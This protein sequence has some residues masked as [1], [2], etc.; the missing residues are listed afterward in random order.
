MFVET[1]CNDLSVSDRFRIFH[2]RHCLQDPPP[3]DPPDGTLVC[4]GFG[5]V[6]FVSLVEY[7]TYAAD[8]SKLSDGQGLYG[9]AAFG[10]GSMSFD[11]MLLLPDDDYVG[12]FTVGV[13]SYAPWIRI[14]GPGGTPMTD[15]MKVPAVGGG[16]GGN[17][18]NHAPS[19]HA[20]PRLAE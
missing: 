9:P 14:F 1:E 16:S 19:L 18:A 13:G 6:N 12:L 5:A 8:G 20:F 7:D 2:Q 15:F 3:C 11:D 17:Q 10:Q 4:R